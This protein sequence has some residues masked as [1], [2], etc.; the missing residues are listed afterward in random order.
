MILRD[1]ELREKVLLEA[2]RFC[3]PQYYSYKKYT[4]AYC[5]GFYIIIDIY[6]YVYIVKPLSIRTTKPGILDKLK[7]PLRLPVTLFRPPLLYGGIVKPQVSGARLI[8]RHRVHGWV[9]YFFKGPYRFIDHRR[10]WIEGECIGI[11]GSASE[12]DALPPEQAIPE[13]IKILERIH[14]KLRSEE[15]LFW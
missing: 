1:E 7:N 5:N 12:W 13:M 15:E 6:K 2:L 4:V 14:D 3:S 11:L 10:F 8:R 9:L